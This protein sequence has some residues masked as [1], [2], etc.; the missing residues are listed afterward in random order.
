MPTPIIFKPRINNYD[1]RP[2]F[3]DNNYV[4]QWPTHGPDR[5]N[6]YNINSSNTQERE[7]A[8][9]WGRWYE[10]ILYPPT[11][12]VW[13]CAPDTFDTEVDKNG[14]FLDIET[15]RYPY[16]VE[17]SIY[18]HTDILGDRYEYTPADNLGRYL[19][20]YGP[21]EVGDLVTFIDRGQNIY[22]GGIVERFRSSIDYDISYLDTTQHIYPNP[23]PVHVMTISLNN[24][25][26]VS[27]QA[28][29]RFYSEFD[30][31]QNP[32]IIGKP[33]G[34]GKFT[35]LYNKRYQDKRKGLT[36]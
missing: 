10:T 22:F 14:R 33:I 3:Y 34:Y 32:L 27:G 18:D 9:L 11:N 20:P 5:A 17:P 23:E 26:G 36:I 19:Y 1:M 16:W 35:V 12:S 8:Y 15:M 25:Q 24:Y 30:P 28:I 4:I 13:S 7:S 2:E 29:Y 6:P 21:Q 31:V